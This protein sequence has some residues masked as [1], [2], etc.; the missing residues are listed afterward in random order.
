MDHADDDALRR[1]GKARKVGLGADDRERAAIDLGAVADVV[2]AGAH[3][4]LSEGA[5]QVGS[6]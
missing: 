2:A 3:R 1:A 5:V 4:G 6:A